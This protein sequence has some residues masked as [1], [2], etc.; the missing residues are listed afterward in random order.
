MSTFK[1]FILHAGHCDCSSFFPLKHAAK[2]FKQNLCS[3]FNTFVG[4]F[5]ISPQLL[6]RQRVIGG[7]ISV[8]LTSSNFTT[9]GVPSDFIWEERELK[10]LWVQVESL[11]SFFGLPFQAAFTLS[12]LLPIIPFCSSWTLSQ[13]HIFQ[14]VQFSCFSFD[15]S[16]HYRVIF[17]ADFFRVY[18]WI[19]TIYIYK[20]YFSIFVFMVFLIV[21]FFPQKLTTDSTWHVNIFGMKPISH[22]I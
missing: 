8:L 21:I 9:D 18:L 14:H 16:R 5:S 4:F 6:Q 13:I 12:I 2:Q 20:I 15:G 3:H 7:L 19:V 22:C 1:I 17:V 11:T 10:K